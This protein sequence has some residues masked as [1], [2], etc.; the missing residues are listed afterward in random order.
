VLGGT[1]VVGTIDGGTVGGIDGIDGGAA[2]SPG[3]GFTGGTDGG[4]S[5]GSVAGAPNPGPF[6]P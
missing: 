1:D 3:F 6:A 5:T 2:V 4:T